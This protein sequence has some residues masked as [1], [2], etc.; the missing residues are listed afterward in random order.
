[1]GGLDAATKDKVR[2]QVLL[3]SGT[4]DRPRGMRSNAHA[5]RLPPAAGRGQLRDVLSRAHARD[6][7]SPCTHQ[8]EFYFSDSNLPRDAFLKGKVAET[9]DGWVDVALL[10]I[11]ERMRQ[12][13]KTSNKEPGKVPEETVEAVADALTSSEALVLSDNRQR[14]RRAA[15]LPESFDEVAAAVDERSIYASPFPFDTTLDALMGESVRAGRR[16]RRGALSLLR[17]WRACVAVSA[18]AVAS[19][20]RP[21]LR[22]AVPPPQNSSGSTAQ[23]AACA[24]VAT[25]RARTS[26][27]RC[28][29]SLTRPRR[30]RAWRRCSWST[31]ARRCTWSQRSTT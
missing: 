30:R 31:L 11:F 16:R 22:P 6:S 4:M 8:V 19:P 3:G 9:P 29:W 20:A 5:C 10:C 1:M 14:V 27:G 2:R 24:C 15:P 7:P 12:L 28:L 21:A 26:R 18:A 23:C 25:S 13:L 17:A